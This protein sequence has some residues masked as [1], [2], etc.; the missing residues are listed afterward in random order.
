VP[1]VEYSPI[2]IKPL[3][4]AICVKDAFNGLKK[5]NIVTLSAQIGRS[6]Y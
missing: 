2:F 6:F 3:G 5:L 1:A 4:A